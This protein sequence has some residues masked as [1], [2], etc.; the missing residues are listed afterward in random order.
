M[1]IHKKTNNLL[2]ILVVSFIIVFASIIILVNNWLKQ[3]LK[4]ETLKETVVP[5]PTL[6][7][8]KYKQAPIRMESEKEVSLQEKKSAVA[9]ET[10]DSAKK[11]IKPEPARAGDILVN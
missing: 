5:L 2:L 6:V 1:E 11:E 7:Q 9:G 10:V 8:P 3:A 4:E